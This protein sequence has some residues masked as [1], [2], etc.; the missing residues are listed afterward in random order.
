MHADT[1]LIGQAPTSSADAIYRKVTWRIIPLLFL[2]YIAAYLDRIN[3]GFAQMAIRADL[4]FSGT[5]FS[6]GRVCSSSATCCSKCPV[7]CISSVSARVRRSRG[8]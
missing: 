3:I 8:S 6:F 7:T 1:H 5:A 2:C 4:N